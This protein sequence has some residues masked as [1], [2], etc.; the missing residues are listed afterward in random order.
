MTWH[1][2][3]LVFCYKA[4]KNKKNRYTFTNS[5]IQI[6]PVSPVDHRRKRQ[7]SLGEGGEQNLPK[8][9]FTCPNMTNLVDK[10]HVKNCLN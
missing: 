7:N 8:Y 4:G 10:F 6:S 2:L 3:M 1:F 5:I 9:F